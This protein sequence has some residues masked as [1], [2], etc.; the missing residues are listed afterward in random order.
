MNVLC[1]MAKETENVIQVMNLKNGEII[2]N[3]EVHPVQSVEQLKVEKFLQLES[4]REMQQKT[5]EE[6]W[7]RR[8]D[9]RDSTPE[10]VLTHI[11]GFEEIC[12]AG[13]RYREKARCVCKTF[14]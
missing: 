7:S 12:L 3:L 2:L 14:F 10:K 5:K 11:V 6:R 13:R 1:Y 4:V 9:Q 8:E